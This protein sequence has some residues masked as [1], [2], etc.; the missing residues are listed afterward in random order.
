[1]DPVHNVNTVKY[2]CWHLIGKYIHVIIEDDV[3]LYKYKQFNDD[4]IWRECQ[5]CNGKCKEKGYY[6]KHWNKNAQKDL[7]INNSPISESIGVYDMRPRYQDYF[8]SSSQ[9]TSINS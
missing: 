8:L 5:K 6:V 9:R 4:I 3:L 2:H 7:V 1:M